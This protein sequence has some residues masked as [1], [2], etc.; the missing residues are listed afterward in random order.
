MHVHARSARAWLLSGACAWH[1]PHGPQVPKGFWPGQS[2]VVIAAD[3][4]RQRVTVPPGMGPGSSMQVSFAK[5]RSVP[6]WLS[7]LGQPEALAE[8]L[9]GA[10]N[11]LGGAAANRL[12]LGRASRTPPSPR[13][14][15]G[16]EDEGVNEA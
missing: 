16:E 15:L 13:P 10:A 12:S 4:R 14:A 9:S 3:G 5:P 6:S 7:S 11:R 8:L 2:F 1:A